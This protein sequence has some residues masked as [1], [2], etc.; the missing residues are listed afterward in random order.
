[1]R[2]IIIGSGIAGVTFAEHYRKLSPD[3]KITLLTGENRGYYSR[4]LLS[5][6]FSEE[7]IEKTIILRT[8]NALQEKNICIIPGV[9]VTAIHPEEHSIDVKGIDEIE[10]LDYD[11]LIIATGSAAFI[12]PPFQPYREN[13]F[14]LNSLEDLITLRRFRQP[15]LDSRRKPNWAI[16]G[17]GLIGCELASDLA[18][19]GDK[20]CLFHAMDKLM[21]RQLVEQDS[22]ALLTVLEKLSIEVRLNQAIQR[23]DKESG[24]IA[25]SV[26][27]NR[28]PFDAAIVS[29]GF[30]PRIE[31]AE[32]A[33]LQTGRGI[34]VNQSLQTSHE[35]IYALG[36]V[37]E[38]PNGKLYAYIIPIRHQARWLAEY[39]CG[40]PQQDW[41]P[42]EFSPEAKVHGFQAAHPY[43]F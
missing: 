25:I 31:L 41:R 9:T 29:C 27:N 35:D 1:M 36:D 28:R 2:V 33:G 12:P 16:I 30:K 42:A 23:I 21:E 32:Q 26:D 37:A 38:L 19:S 5:R 43:R 15:F 22:T 24:K 6:G 3:A 17:G 40:Q 4:P 7:D 20:V 39:F 8:F 13:F 18:V 34:R 14:L 11:K 10:Q